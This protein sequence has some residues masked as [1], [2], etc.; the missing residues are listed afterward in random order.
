MKYL[1]DTHILMWH[2]EGNEKLSNEIRERILFNSENQVFVSIISLWEV[3][4]KMN[5]GKYNLFGGFSAFY[6]LVNDNEFEIKSINKKHMDFLFELPL[7]H[8]EPF[9]RLLVATAK[10]EGMT[11][12]SADENIKKYDVQWVWL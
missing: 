8:R 11:L 5:I 10:A 3:A 1:L 2:F 6:K 7:I 12:I 9:D 4:I